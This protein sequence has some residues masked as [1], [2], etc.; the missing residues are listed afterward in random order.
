MLA[1]SWPA[2]FDDPGWWFE[3]KWDGVRVLVEAEP[4]RVRLRSRSG[5][6]MSTTYPELTHLPVDRPTVLDGEIIAFDAGGVPSFGALQQRM[7]ATRPVPG[8]PV[9]LAVFDLLHHGRSL[10]GLPIEERWRRLASLE[11]PGVVRSEPVAENGTALFEAAG[12]LGIEGIVAKRAASTYQ[13]GRRSPDWRKVPI[14][15]RT[16]ALVGGFTPGEGGRSSSFGALQLGLWDEG[17]LRYVGG[18]GS[19]FDEITL[20]RIRQTLDQLG[21][22]PVGRSGDWPPETRF[23]YPVLVAVVEYLN[24]TTAG[25]LRGPSFIGFGDDDPDDVTWESE[26]PGDSGEPSG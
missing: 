22:E 18:V 9:S 19:G 4:G 15:R 20:L 26:G 25:R 24:W 12:D 11:L 23:V 13:P 10:I 16:K 5:R 1:V 17:R 3:V 2:P 14:R 6:D 21:G 7:N 8:T